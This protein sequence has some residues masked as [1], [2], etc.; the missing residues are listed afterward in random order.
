MPSIT[1]VGLADGPVDHG[2]LQSSPQEEEEGQKPVHSQC[3]LARDCIKG[4]TKEVGCKTAFS[5][6]S[7]RH[8][9]QLDIKLH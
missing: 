6:L 3:P 4:T 9:T 1:E 7:H 8:R 2:K 5:D